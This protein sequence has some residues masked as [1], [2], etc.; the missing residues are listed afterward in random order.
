MGIFGPF[1]HHNCHLPTEII[2]EIISYSVPRNGLCISNDPDLNADFATINAL[3]K[4]SCMV[5]SKVLDRVFKAPLQI[6]IT[7]SRE[8]RCMFD[9]KPFLQTRLGKAFALPLYKWENIN[10][11]FAPELRASACGHR[12]GHFLSDEFLDADRA[13]LK[14]RADLRCICRQSEAFAAAFIKYLNTMR[15]NSSPRVT[16]NW[17]ANKGVNDATVSRSIPLWESR[18]LSVPLQGWSWLVW[19]SD[20][21]A[22]INLPA[23]LLTGIISTSRWVHPSS[24]IW[25][26]RW[27]FPRTELELV[28]RSWRL[29][30]K[31]LFEDWS[32]FSEN[33]PYSKSEP[34]VRFIITITSGTHDFGTRYRYVAQPLVT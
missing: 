2:S 5:R 23:K 33:Q 25:L 3:C 14:L 17:D 10:V 9:T 22:Q 11:T 32:L 20:V 28:S 34:N 13:L 30:W 16:F 26:D 6:Y 12:T 31:E 18:S 1:S 21:Q 24:Y 29:H 8:C 4:T 15:Y 19:R 7:N 27:P